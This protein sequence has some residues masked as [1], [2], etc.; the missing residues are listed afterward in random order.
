[1]AGVPRAISQIAAHTQAGKE[2]SGHYFIV[3]T[4]IDVVHLLDL[5]KPG[6][7]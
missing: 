6:P 7:R 4:V 1:M 2:T 5:C 3:D